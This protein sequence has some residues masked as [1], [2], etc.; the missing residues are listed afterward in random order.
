VGPGLKSIGGF[1]N[2]AN[3]WLNRVDPSGTAVEDAANKIHEGAA[4][5]S[6]FLGGYFGSGFEEG[7]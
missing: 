5:S 6:A 4:W 7:P 3:N 2:Q 1:A